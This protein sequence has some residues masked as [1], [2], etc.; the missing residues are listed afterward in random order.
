MA[1]FHL[2]IANPLSPCIKLESA[3]DLSLREWKKQNFLST[4]D[5]ETSPY[6]QSK[7]AEP[8]CKQVSVKV[9]EVLSCSIDKGFG[10]TLDKQETLL[11]HS[12]KT[13][14]KR[15]HG[16]PSQLSRHDE[17]LVSPNA[18]NTRAPVLTDSATSPS[19][20][21]CLRIPSVYCLNKYRPVDDTADNND[22]NNREEVGLQTSPVQVAPD[23]SL[24]DAHSSAEISANDDHVE[25]HMNEVEDLPA[26]QSPGSSDLE[27]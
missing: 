1:A 16:S 12:T 26:P 8:A 22:G 18:E 23:D 9:G 3:K 14:D 10:V 17:D 25:E 6:V 5:R 20:P 19:P 21:T 4:E 11:S 13:S 27:V 7:E 15:Q 24:P 2:A